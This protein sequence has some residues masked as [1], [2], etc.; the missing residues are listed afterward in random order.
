MTP[1]ARDRIG[2]E[3]DPSVYRNAAADP[4]SEDDAEHGLDPGGSAVDR[5]GE[6]KAVGVIGQA[7]GARQRRFEIALQ[8]TAIQPCGVRVLYQA[9]RW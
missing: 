1:L 4:C 2:A 3:V 9:S 8:R 6:G 7:D 5:L